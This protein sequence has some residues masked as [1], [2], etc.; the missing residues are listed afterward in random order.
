[1]RRHTPCGR[2]VLD[3][4]G[5]IPRSGLTEQVSNVPCDIITVDA[6]QCDIGDHLLLFCSPFPFSIPFSFFLNGKMVEFFNFE[7][8]EKMIT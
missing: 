4:P 3:A 5:L 6:C 1:V 8:K 2:E 7:K